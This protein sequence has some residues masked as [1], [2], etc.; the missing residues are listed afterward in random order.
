MKS[1]KIA[2][3]G[4][5]GLIGSNFFNQIKKKKFKIEKFNSKNISKISSTNKYDFVFCSALPAEKWFANKY[6]RKD[7]KNMKNLI[8]KIKKINTKL[9][10]LV[11][12]IDVNF[13]HT[14]GK[15]RLEFEKF[16]NKKFKKKIIIR[17]PG[18]FG[19]GLKKNIIFDLIN[20]KNLENI[21]INDKFQWYDLASISKDTLKLIRDKKTGLF[22]LY[23]QPIQNSEILKFFP[24]INIK[25]KRKKPVLYSFKPKNGY[26]TDKKII[27]SRIKKF[28][29]SNEF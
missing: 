18:V 10:I 27:L 6:P 26:F 8:N 9:F 22:E 7:Y 25:S 4:Y 29:K 11:S 28:I 2:L 3:I 20:K 13:R 24:K 12:T 19:K 23:S 21:F 17:L 16:I 5:T 14:Y 15:N 1:N